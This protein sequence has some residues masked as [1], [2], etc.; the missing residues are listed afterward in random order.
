LASGSDDSTILLWDLTAQRKIGKVAPPTAAEL[1]VLWAGL[2]EDAAKA[3]EALWSLVF[4]A[5]QSIPLLKE[6]LKPITSVP[7]D[8][9]AKCIAELDD[10]RFAARE[11]AAKAL[12]ELGDPA[13]TAVRKA[14][15]DKPGLE[16]KRRLEPVLESFDKNAI[17]KLRA[18]AALEHI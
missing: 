7:A 18:I 16:T 1:S 4:A 12:E 2:K 14:L 5:E 13:E 10:D 3:Y 17:Q 6:R 8:Q 9:L 11:K 15:Q